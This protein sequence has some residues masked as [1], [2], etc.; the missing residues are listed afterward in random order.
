ML[1]HLIIIFCARI[2]GFVNH[3]GVYVPLKHH[4]SVTR[5]KELAV[6]SVTHSM[7]LTRGESPEVLNRPSGILLAC[8]RLSYVSLLK[9]NGKPLKV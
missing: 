1:L 8:L 4:E 5:G 2:Q 6:P 3:L 9:E 7:Y